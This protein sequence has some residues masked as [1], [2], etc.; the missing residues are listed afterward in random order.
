MKIVTVIAALEEHM[1]ERH[2]HLLGPN[3]EAL[4]RGVAIAEK[5]VLKFLLFVQEFGRKVL[6]VHSKRYNEW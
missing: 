3:K 4:G 5:C 1:P 2:R 6:R